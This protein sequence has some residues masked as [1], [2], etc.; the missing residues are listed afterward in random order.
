[1]KDRIT[2]EITL[3]PSG[4]FASASDLDHLR[5]LKA[6]GGETHPAVYIALQRIGLKHGLHP[7]NINDETG[8]FVV[9]RIT[10]KGGA[11]HA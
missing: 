2:T 3:A 4:V 5:D 10:K 6:Q 1:M 8:E 7:C 11:S 9:L